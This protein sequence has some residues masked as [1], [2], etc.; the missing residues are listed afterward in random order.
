MAG[1]LRRRKRLVFLGNY[2]NRNVGD[3]A[4]LQVL[5][6]RYASAY[7]NHDQ[8]AFAREYPEDI[9]RS[10]RAEPLETSVRSAL[11]ALRSTDILVVGGGGLFGAKMGPAARFIPLYA[12]FAR[13]TGT[14][15][16][17]ESIGYYAATPRLQRGL[18]F[19]SMLTAARVTV[20]DGASLRSAAPVARFRRVE[21]VVDPGYDVRPV[22]PA[23]VERLLSAEGATPE[24]GGR[25]IGVSA[26]RIIADSGASD[27]LR[28]SLAAACRRLVDRGDTVIFIPF[29]HD[30]HKWSEQDVAFADEIVAEAGPGPRLIV[31]RDIYTPAQ[32]S[33]LLRRCDA[34]LA[35]RLHAQIF[36]HGLG[37]PLLPIAY[38]EKRL[39]FV[40]EHGYPELH[41][42]DLQPDVLVERLTAL[43]DQGDVSPTVITGRTRT[44]EQPDA[45]ARA[46]T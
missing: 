6:D 2:G 9:G 43:A 32:A 24:A 21:L 44:G 13:L 16:I 11:G 15:L 27:R 22:E 4:I 12:L 14:T 8:L 3:D 31:L 39:A 37:V 46:G 36:S 42:G 18:L 7:P 40:R 35:M 10:S 41:L 45:S 26:K 29:C 19:L 1:S 28:T 17:Y 38:E 25:V 23:E 20:R 30:P 34:V 33:G 5:S